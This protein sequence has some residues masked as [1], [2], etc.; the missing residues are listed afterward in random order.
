MNKPKPYTTRKYEGDDRYSWA[1][2]HYGNPIM[3]GLDRNEA[4]SRVKEYNKKGTHV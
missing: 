2:F 3:T 4:Q 1:I